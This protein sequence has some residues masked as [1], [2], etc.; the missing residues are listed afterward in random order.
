MARSHLTL[1]ALAT[2]AVPGFEPTGTQTLSTGAHGEFDTA[3]VSQRG[4]E[5]YLVRVPTS[6][7]SQNDLINQQVALEA[8]TQGVRS[9]LIFEVP[10]IVGRAPIAKTFGLVFNYLPGNV[11]SMRDFEANLSLAILVGRA[12]GSIHQLPTGFVSEAGLPV[13]S[14]AETQRQ[15]AVLVDRGR[16]SGLLPAVLLQRWSE[17]VADETLWQF[18]PTVIHGAL[19]VDRFVIGEDSVSAVLGWGSLRVGDP[20]WDLHW[21]TG[22]DEQSQ[23]QAF[24]SYS[25]VRASAVD[26]KVR[27]R[28][29]L[30]SELELVRWLVH[31]LE[32]GRQDIVDDAVAM[33]D[34]MVDRVRDESENAVGQAPAQ[35]LNVTEVE[36][37]LEALP[38]V[39]AG[40]E[41]ATAEVFPE[42]LAETAPYDPIA[43]TQEHAH[44]I[45]PESAVP[46]FVSPE[47]VAD[48]S[49]GDALFSEESLSPDDV[50]TAPAPLLAPRVDE[51]GNP[52]PQRDAPRFSD[53]T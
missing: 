7:A 24:E 22:L 10:T 48:D 38:E 49:F 53:E 29:S 28:A 16:A 15:T 35:V 36:S 2:A 6:M 21:L 1:A 11:I 41:H 20:A 8:M 12:T 30:Y 23:N 17:A 44:F 42:D 18:E 25:D 3:L 19:G 4:G 50:E 52:L 5:T 13:F 33:L 34:R 14:A 47:A 31:G 40:T 26:P 27:Q 51:Y 45:A 9:R 37:L 39:E 46:G 43:E 32:L